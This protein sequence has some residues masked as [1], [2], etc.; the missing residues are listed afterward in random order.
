MQVA[1][2]ALLEDLGVPHF[3]AWVKTA[4]LKHGPIPSLLP[5]AKHVDFAR[6]QGWMDRVCEQ[7]ALVQC[8]AKTRDEASVKSGHSAFLETLKEKERKLAAT[9]TIKK[10]SGGFITC[11]CKSQDVDVDQ[12]QTRSSDEPMTMYALCRT[13][14]A[15]WVVRD[16]SG[17]GGIGV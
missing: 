15:T 8:G 17:L 1:G 5:T 12:R 16:G 11:K 9:T 4:S 3:D 13:C 6:M 7:A 2:T 10:T 14:G